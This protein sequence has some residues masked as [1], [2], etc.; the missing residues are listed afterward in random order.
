MQILVGQGEPDPIF[1]QLGE[2][3]GQGKGGE[4]LK[5]VDVDQERT[6]ARPVA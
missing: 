1:A 2:H 5:F 3:V 4:A 6:N